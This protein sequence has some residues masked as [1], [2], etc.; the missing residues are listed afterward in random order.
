MTGLMDISP[1]TWCI[2]GSVITGWVQSTV[3]LPPLAAANMSG[4][5]IPSPSENTVLPR[6]E[7]SVFSASWD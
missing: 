5:V 4:P 1:I 2:K 3:Y 7:V 6:P